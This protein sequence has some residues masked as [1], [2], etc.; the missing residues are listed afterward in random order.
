MMLKPKEWDNLGHAAHLGGA[1]FGLV[2]AV[3]LRP[4]DAF[5]NILYLG[6]MSLPL[7][8][9]SYEIFIKKRIG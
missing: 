3:A 2:F 8:Y 1:F 5:T 9:L 4:V 7:I 6:A